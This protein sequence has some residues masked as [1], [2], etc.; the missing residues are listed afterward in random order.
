MDQTL[1]FLF[2]LPLIDVNRRD[3]EGRTL[4][5]ELIKRGYPFPSVLLTLSGMDWNVRDPE[6]LDTALII[7]SK[8]KDYKAS[9]G[10]FGQQRQFHGALEV[11]QRLG[12]DINAQ[13]RN[14]NTAIMEAVLCGNVDAF[15][16]ISKKNE[17]RLDI[18]N[19]AGVTVLDVVGC[20]RPLDAP[21]A[22]IANAISAAMN[23]KHG[24]TTQT[25]LW[26]IV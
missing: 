16:A 14:G 3:R 17:C 26:P 19:N 9:F 10:E 8:Q 2:S 20:A 6:T 25:M 7:M 18:R 22:E 15:A 23:A 1:E 21:R 4:L 11:L 5:I 12:L 24:S 13:N